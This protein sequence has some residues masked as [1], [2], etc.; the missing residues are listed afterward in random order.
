MSETISVP[1]MCF[2][3]ISIILFTNC[4][5]APCTEIIT[6]SKFRACI[7]YCAFCGA[8]LKWPAQAVSTTSQ[9]EVSIPLYISSLQVTFFTSAD[10][11]Q[12]SAEPEI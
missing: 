11:S 2:T 8:F 3:S 10:F 6:C 5:L 7:N 12:N 9:N 1:P 4:Y